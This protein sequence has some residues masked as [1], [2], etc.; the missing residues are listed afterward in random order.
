MTTHLHG[1]AEHEPQHAA[2]DPKQLAPCQI[3]PHE[4][5]H[6]SVAV[7]PL[8]TPQQTTNELKTPLL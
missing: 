8:R 3:R 4:P 7:S 1:P 2:R 5:D 6:L